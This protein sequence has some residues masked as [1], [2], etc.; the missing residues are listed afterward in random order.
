MNEKIISI[1]DNVRYWDTCPDEYKKEIEQ[2]LNS[3]DKIQYDIINT[4]KKLS[5]S[6]MMFDI[7]EELE[8]EKNSY[9]GD[10]ANGYEDGVKKGIN[11]VVTYLKTRI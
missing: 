3:H 9:W 2:F 5:L 4:I 1:L 10:Y 6:D 7:E 11:F 8:K